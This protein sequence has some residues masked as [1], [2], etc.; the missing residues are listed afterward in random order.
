MGMKNA[1]GKWDMLVCWQFHIFHFLHH[2]SYNLFPCIFCIIFRIRKV[3]FVQ[4]TLEV[5]RLQSIQQWIQQYGHLWVE[6]SFGEL[7]TLTLLAVEISIK[8]LI[9]VFR[10]L[11]LNREKLSL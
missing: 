11:S 6:S 4:P 1:N 3:Y 10:Y 8:L 2:F 7:T 5:L 9:K